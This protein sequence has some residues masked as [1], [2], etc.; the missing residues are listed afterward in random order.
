MILNITQEIMIDECNNS[1]SFSQ[2]A[3][4]YGISRKTVS[5]YCKKYNIKPSLPKRRK[6]FVNDIFFHTA[7]EKSFY[8][9]GFI[10]ADGCI[11]KDHS[12][13]GNALVIELSKKDQ[14]LLETFVNDI[15]F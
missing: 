11:V 3:E 10:A 15:G 6:Y 14:T 2:I 9:A 7:T 13:V 12:D 5:K 1:K 4:K 8:W